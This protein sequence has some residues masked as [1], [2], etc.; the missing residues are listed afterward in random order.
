M[1][2][3]YFPY[4]FTRVKPTLW[5]ML[6][7]ER[8]LV[9]CFSF[10]GLGRRKIFKGRENNYCFER[11]LKKRMRWRFLLFLIMIGFR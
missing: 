3:V 6:E 11:S 1:V 7:K 10:V 8:V 9:I 4:G 2:K 5:F